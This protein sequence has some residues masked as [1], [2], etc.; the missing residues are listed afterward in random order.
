MAM[1]INDVQHSFGRCNLSP[2]FLDT[3]YQNFMA[4]SPEVAALFSKTDFVK[5]KRM[6]QMSLNMLI[7][8]AS[9][10]GVVDG[11]MKQL[12]EKHSHRELN[13]EPRHYTAWLDS[14]LKAVAQYDREFTP[15][16][17]QAW[18]KCLRKGIDMMKAAY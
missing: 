3:F 11:Y 5:Q 9:G 1:D 14:L 16:L 7:V 2:K 15:E 6:L 4:T 18:R 13:I 10:N 12:A 17:E 8:Y